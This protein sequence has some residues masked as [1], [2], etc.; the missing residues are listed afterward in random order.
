MKLSIIAALAA[1]LAL[2]ACSDADWSHAMSFTGMN[3]ADQDQDISQS[4]AEVAPTPVKTV[5][6]PVA[7]AGQP[8]AFCES[9]AKQDSESNAFDAATQQRAFVSSY[10]QCVR[11]FGNAAPQ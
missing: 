5:Q 6:T 8:N 11:I 2:S 7:Q 1:A 3:H 9:V 10:Q 4:D